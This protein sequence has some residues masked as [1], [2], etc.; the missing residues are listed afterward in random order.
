MKK[1]LSLL[2]VALGMTTAFCQVDNRPVN[3]GDDFSLEGALAMFK[4]ANSLE[5]FEKLLNEENNHVNNLDL[6]NDDDID[7]IVV[8]DINKTLPQSGLKKQGKIKRC[9][10]LKAMPICILKIPSLNLPK[11]KKA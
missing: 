4:K 7:Y 5:E 10:K 6:N 2:L 8:E 1:Q 11:K 9:Y 3:T